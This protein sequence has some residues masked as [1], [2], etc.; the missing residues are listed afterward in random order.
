MKKELVR[1]IV[2][3]ALAFVLMFSSL[4]YGAEAI[5]VTKVQ[6]EEAISTIPDV[7]GVQ[8]I[9]S[10]KS[11]KGLKQSSL[12]T[13]SSQLKIG[14]ATTYKKLDSYLSNENNINYVQFNK[15][16]EKGILEL[17]STKTG[18][19]LISIGSYKNNASAVYINQCSSSGKV[20][21]GVCAQ[22]IKPGE[23]IT[24]CIP[25]KANTTYQLN[26][27]PANK[28]DIFL[29]MG[30]VVPGG[31]SMTL[32]TSYAK[33][34]YTVAA[35]TDSNHK[36]YTTYLKLKAKSNGL[37]SVQ[38]QDIIGQNNGIKLTLCN[39]KKTAI[40][41]TSTLKK[42]QNDGKESIDSSYYGISGVTKGTTY[43]LKVQTAA[44]VYALKYS[45]AKYTT[46]PG[47]KKSKATKITRGKSKNVTLA[48]STSTGSQWYKISVP[49][50]KKVTV[51]FDGYVAPGTSVKM[52]LLKSNGKTNVKSMTINGALHSKLSGKFEITFSKKGTYYVKISKTSK[53][54]SAAYKIS[55]K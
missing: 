7:P 18:N 52:Q 25:V 31:T 37:L 17:K 5:S 14:T 10:Q 26:F 22:G 8:D 24:S 1:K 27:T 28:N 44:P 36:T 15:S 41:A 13:A 35:G 30:V 20:L 46:K 32:P 6:K 43:Y 40:S 23:A 4:A 42:F 3:L 48:A 50:K 21:N 19:L 39:S 38:A 54:S 49:A 47:T 34:D 12:K 11:V 51:K 45:T 2:P 55:Y 9:M 29:I 33:D 16:V 53:K